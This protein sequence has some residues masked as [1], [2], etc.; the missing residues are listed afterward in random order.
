MA[1]TLNISDIKAEITVRELNVQIR[2]PFSYF[3][4]NTEGQCGEYRSIS[5]VNAIVFNR[6]VLHNER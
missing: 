1:V 6:A 3:H 5:A 4:D 2:L